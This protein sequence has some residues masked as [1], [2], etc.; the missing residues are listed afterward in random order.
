MYIITKYNIK[1]IHQ[2][3]KCKQSFPHRG[4]PGQTVIYPCKTSIQIKFLS[5]RVIILFSNSYNRLS[6]M[7]I[8]PIVIQYIIILIGA[9]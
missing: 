8:I 4:T 7:L 1:H 5:D 9:E 2:K 3:K 6:Q